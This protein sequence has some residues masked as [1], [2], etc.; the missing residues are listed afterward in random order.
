MDKFGEVSGTIL[1]WEEFYKWAKKN[2]RMNMS[3]KEGIE[4]YIKLNNKVGKGKK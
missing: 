3:F 4:E 2:K 1:E